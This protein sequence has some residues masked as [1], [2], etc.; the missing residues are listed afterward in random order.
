MKSISFD[1]RDAGRFRQPP[2]PT[3]LPRSVSGSIVK[4]ANLHPSL[5]LLVLIVAAC[6]CSAQNNQQAAKM[7]NGSSVNQNSTSQGAEGRGQYIVED[8]SRCGQ[9]H[10]PRDSN[11]V[12]DRS[13]WL[14]GAPVWLKSAEPVEDW[15]LQA[16]RIAGALPGTDA[17]MV[18]LLTTG[19]WRT[20]TYLRPPMPQFRMSRQD[21]ESVI[22][23]LKSVKT[24]PK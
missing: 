24:A 17:E 2:S 5:V 12:P 22:A 16:P 18:T 6:F 10:T 13:R 9:C 21:A 8:L 20:G 4:A 14:Q 7:R 1:A 15:P 3:G 11:G 23:Y 19:I